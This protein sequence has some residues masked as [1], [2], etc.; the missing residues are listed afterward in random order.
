MIPGRKIFIKKE[1]KYIEMTKDDF[2]QK[3]GDILESKLHKDILK[4]YSV[5][6]EFE[7]RMMRECKVQRVNEHIVIMDKA[8]S[9]VFEVLHI[10][11][12]NI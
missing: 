5:Y 11:E 7:Y 1:D 3:M 10:D 2:A 6:L 9:I 4:K 8:T 12:K